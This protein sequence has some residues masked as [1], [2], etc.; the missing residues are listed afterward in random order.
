MRNLK[1]ISSVVLLF[2]CITASSQSIIVNSASFPETNLNAEDLTREV[3]ID[4]GE[5]SSISNFQ[6]KDNYA[7]QFPNANRSW[8]YFEKGTSNFPFEK[9]IVLTSGYAKEAQGPSGGIVSKG[10]YSWV[11]DAAANTLAGNVT[12]NATVFEFDFVPYGD[13]I[14]FNYI[15][16][17]EEYPGFTCTS[18]NDVFGFI[19]S[20]PGITNDP[21]LGGRNIA[22]LPNGQ[23]VTIN[24]VNNDY[25]GDSTYYVAGP[26]NDIQYGGRTTVLTAEAD[27]IPGS[28]YH[29]R[30]LV[31]DS[32]DTMYDSAVFLEAGSFNLGSTLV[33]L[34]GASL[35][36][37]QT[38]C[39]ESSFTIVAQVSAPNASFQWY[40]NGDLIPGATGPTYPATQSGYYSVVIVSESCSTEVG[41]DLEFRDKPEVSPHQVSQ[42]S[43][44]GSYT[45]NLTN[46]NTDICTTPGGIFSYFHTLAGAQT[47][48]PADRINN[49]TNFPV[50]TGTT[51]VYVRVATGPGCFEVAE[52]TL[53]VGEGP[54][55]VPNTYELCDDDGDGFAVFDLTSQANSMVVSNPDSLTFEYYLD[56]A[57]TQQITTPDNFTNTSNPQ[58]IYVKIFDASSGTEDCVSVEILTLKVNE[59]PALQADEITICDN[60]NDN[61]EFINLTQNDIVVTPGITVSLHYY[62]TIGGTEIADPTNYEVTASPTVIHVLVKNGD[63]TCEDYQ[64]LT[65]NFNQAPLVENTGLDMCSD[66]DTAVFHLPDAIA[67]IV[68]SPNGLDFDFYATYNDALLG[69]NNTLPDDYTN[70]SN[71]QTVFV[72]VLNENGCYNIAEV[73]LAVHNGPDNM[74]FTAELCDDD[75]DGFAT[76]DLTAYAQNLVANPNNI[77]FAYFLDAAATQQIN[78]PDSFTNT[79]NPQTVYVKLVDNTDPNLCSSIGELTLKVNEF[80]ALQADEITIC[81]NLNDNSEFI[82]L[83]Q[84]DI[85]VTP[86]ITVSLHY[87]ETI[88]GTEIADPTNY[89]VT[90][91]PTVIHVL[92]KN[93][94]GSCEDYQTLTINFMDAPVVTDELIVIQNCSLTPY[95]IFYL[96]GINEAM[97]DDISGLT[98]TYHLTFDDAAAGVNGLPNNY[99]NTSPD[100]IVYVRVR[101]ANGCYDIGEVQLSTVLKHEVIQDTMTVC[102]DPYE[103]SDGIAHFDLTQYHNQIEALLGGNNYTINYFTSIEDAVSG[104]NAIQHP[105]NFQNQTNPQTIYAQASSGQG[106]CAGIVDFQVEVLPVPV[107]E[108]PEFVA[109]CVDD[110]N[111]SYTMPGTYETYQWTDPNGNVISDSALVNFTQEGTYTL[112]VTEAG[113]DCPGKRDIQVIM[114][115]PPV[116]IEIQ[117][118][119]NKVSVYANGG[120]SPYQYSYNNGLTWSDYGVFPDFD[121]GLFE[122]IV[123][124]KYGCIS[125]AKTF[126]VLGIPN[127]ISPNGDGKNDYWFVRGLEAY[128]NANIKIFDRFGKV[129][130]DRKLGTDYRWDGTYMGRNVSSGD[131]WYIIT[132]EDGKKLTGHISVRNY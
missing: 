105:E 65:I 52:L 101:N 22:R 24:N 75:G 96:P 2:A 68:T 14:S 110:F 71:T 112:E 116:I 51:I 13:H 83:T 53:T 97:V 23:P 78:T 44:S 56:A 16:A 120:Y 131:Y 109:F 74:P 103:E 125:T 117:V 61:S 62:E 104:N 130:V 92:V 27:V 114:D 123:K 18:F 124:S 38:V 42:C 67:E 1:N 28:T 5:C 20:G 54:E 59:F 90:A 31:A 3:L 72:R 77:A 102:D 35:G 19:I 128:P 32:S 8:G 63:E 45:F 115:T 48:N 12:N 50:N 73:E 93:A 57:A 43:P 4:G 58:Q 94:A 33:D 86:G 41:I 49:F 30:L 121:A 113:L 87:Y 21:G 81:D 99:Q 129:F 85:V 118:D 36:E 95:T 91:S 89:E 47:A 88:G 70:T 37:N 69:G 84:N 66:D 119:G 79:S 107:F 106:G 126:G 9:G 29:I 98:F 100:Q 17:S 10:D 26:F 55:T 34:D 76:F 82:N 80:P 15:F 39:G 108:L 111:K 122:M 60:L 64:T 46:F 132:F 25:C 7:A 11:G 6:K 127:F 40:F